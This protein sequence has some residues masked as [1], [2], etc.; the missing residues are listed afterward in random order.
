MPGKPCTR[1]LKAFFASSDGFSSANS[2]GLVMASR[3]SSVVIGG[4]V[5]TPVTMLRRPSTTRAAGWLFSLAIA[6]EMVAVRGC[7]NRFSGRMTAAAS[8]APIPT[9]T[10]R[11]SPR[12]TRSTICGPT[13]R[14]RGAIRASGAT[15]I[16]PSPRGMSR[17]CII[18]PSRICGRTAVICPC[19][20]VCFGASA[21]SVPRLTFA[22]AARGDSAP[23]IPAR[24]AARVPISTALPGVTAVSKLPVTASSKTPPIASPARTSALTFHA[25]SLVIRWVNVVP[26]S[27]SAFIRV[28]SDARASAGA[29]PRTLP[30][31]AS[32]KKAMPCTDSPVIPSGF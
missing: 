27:P 5:I 18:A 1:P 6:E 9:P 30:I 31:C 26:D 29:S 13:R 20:K 21:A 32:E 23:A 17:V 10:P 28:L 12:I 11:T 4:A 7:S 15:P 22:L 16:R 8:A 25:A 19:R 24:M 3:G 2:C 14:P